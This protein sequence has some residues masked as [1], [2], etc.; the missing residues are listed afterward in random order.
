MLVFVGRLLFQDGILG[1]KTVGE[2]CVKG[3]DPMYLMKREPM[4]GAVFQGEYI[5]I[6]FKV[7]TCRTEVA[8]E[9]SCPVLL[10]C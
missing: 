2:N 6:S 1:V 5:R 9:W 10:C 4:G 8:V 3:L 7:V